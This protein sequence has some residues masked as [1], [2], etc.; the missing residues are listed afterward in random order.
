MRYERRDTRSEGLI[1][2]RPEAGEMDGGQTGEFTVRL[3]R[4]LGMGNA[5]CRG[6]GPANRCPAYEQG[7]WASRGNEE[8]DQFHAQP[9]LMRTSYADAGRCEILDD[10]ARIKFAVGIVHGAL[11]WLSGGS[12]FVEV[13]FAVKLHLRGTQMALPRGGEM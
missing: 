1:E 6:A 13:R 12:A 3:G 11:H 8:Y 7:R 10:P 2:T 4:Y 9:Y 5:E